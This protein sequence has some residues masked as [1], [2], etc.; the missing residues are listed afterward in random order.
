MRHGAMGL[1]KGTLAEG[2]QARKVEKRG[3]AKG[4][5]GFGFLRT[6]SMDYVA[7]DGR[8]RL[9]GRVGWN[10][11]NLA[12]P[13]ERPACLPISQH[14]VPDPSRSGCEGDFG[15]RFYRLGLMNGQ[16]S[17]DRYSTITSLVH[18][19]TRP[20]ISIAS[21]LQ[22]RYACMRAKTCYPEADRQTEP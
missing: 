18:V 1:T 17:W 2:D 3:R 11:C 13:L 22:P 5:G 8:R 7:E 20:L 16:R 9:D 21:Q 14:N 12:W 10:E 4:R 6:V 19:K 15:R